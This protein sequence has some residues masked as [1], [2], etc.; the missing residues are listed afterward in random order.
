MRHMWAQTRHAHIY[1]WMDLTWMPRI[2]CILTFVYLC[3]C[4]VGVPHMNMWSAR[5][6]VPPNPLLCALLITLLCVL[7]SFWSSCPSIEYIA[8]QALP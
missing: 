1:C 3:T 2:I 5:H 6:A 8:G 4:L 7:P